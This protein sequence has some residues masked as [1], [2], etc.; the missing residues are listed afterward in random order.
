MP[1]GQHQQGD[2]DDGHDDAKSGV[3]DSLPY[4]DQREDDEDQEESL[5]KQAQ[6]GLEP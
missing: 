3:H 1:D 2:C 4:L 5:A 6:L